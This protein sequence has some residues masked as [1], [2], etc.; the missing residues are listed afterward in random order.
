M[1]RYPLRSE[2]SREGPRQKRGVLWIFWWRYRPRI[3]KG[4]L[5]GQSTFFLTQVYACSP[6]YFDQFISPRAKAEGSYEFFFLKSIKVHKKQNIEPKKIIF[7]TCKCTYYTYVITNV[8]VLKA[9]ARA[10]IIFFVYLFPK[11]IFD[12]W[13][14]S[15]IW[16]YLRKVLTASPISIKDGILAIRPLKTFCG[17]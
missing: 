9:K 6:L 2:V 1:C 15:P 16:K 7:Y 17:P 8:E 13:L 3:L 4:Y 14:I 5:W 12:Y 11:M 10:I